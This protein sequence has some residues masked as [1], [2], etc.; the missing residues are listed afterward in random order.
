MRPAESE[1]DLLS[2]PG[3]RGVAAIAVDLQD[4]REIAKMRV[5]TLGLA[6]RSIDIGDDRWIAAAPWPVIAGIGPELPGLGPPA[7]GIEHRR[8]RL[9]GEQPLGPAKLFEDM[10]T[11]GA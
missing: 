11:Q 1:P 10:V 7:P 8:R 4:A 5:R 9:V 3:E 2:P 6:I